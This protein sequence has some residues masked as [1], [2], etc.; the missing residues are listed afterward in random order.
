MAPGAF[1]V[2][3]GIFFLL[4]KGFMAV[5]AIEV[6]GLLQA[7]DLILFFLGIMA[8]RA[9]LCRTPGD[10]DILFILVIVVAVPAAQLV[11]FGMLQV[12]EF[13]R[14]LSLFFISLVINQDA[15][16]FLCKSRGPVLGRVGSISST[17]CGQQNPG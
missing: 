1:P 13:Y 10:P 15:V 12:G 9:L 5:P 6:K 17:W 14:A 7:C 3:T 2:G 11:I 16:Q 4:L 8:L